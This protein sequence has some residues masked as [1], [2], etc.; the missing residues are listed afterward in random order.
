MS[1]RCIT[2]PTLAAIRG[3]VVESVDVNYLAIMVASLSGFVIGALWYSPAI[4][5]NK[6]MQA[7]GITEEAIAAS[8]KPR[9]F[10]AAFVFLLIM[11]YCLAM[12]LAA[13]DVNAQ[14]GAFYGFLTG[15][16]WLFFAIG[17]TALFE[18]RSWTYIWVNGGYWVITMTVMGAIL[19][20][21]K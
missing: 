13:P 15:F 6:W 2:L 8:N 3:N 18:L 14:I 10:V 17:T 16:G 4:V 5:G 12:F 9:I 20:A 19:G 1:S 7:A 11:S 21:W